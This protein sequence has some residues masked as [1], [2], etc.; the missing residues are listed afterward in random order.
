M[1]DTEIVHP[2]AADEME[3]W[4]MSLATTFLDDPATVAA[5]VPARVPSW[6]ADRAW[7]ARADGRWVATLRTTPR[8]LT[9]PGPDTEI[10][11]DALTNVTVSATHRRQGLLRAML[12]ESL[13]SARDRG[14][15][16]SILIAAEW[17]IY[18]RFG[19]APSSDSAR[20]TLWTR[21]PGS[22]LIG[23]HTGT[24]RQVTPDELGQVAPE[25]FATARRQRAGNID[26]PSYWRDR[27]LGINGIRRGDQQPVVHIV[28]E[29]PDGPDG[30]VTW[31]ST[32]NWSLTGELGEVTVRDLIATNDEAYLSLWQYLIGIDVVDRI[33]LRDRPVDEP[34]HWL[35]EDGRVLRQ[36]H[37]IDWMWLRIIDV[38]AALSA[39]RYAVD[40]S[41]V[42]E[43]VDPD[44]P[45]GTGRPDAPAGT[46][47]AAGRYVLDGSTDGA[48]CRPTTRSAD[49][50][51]H[52]RALAASY[53]GGVSL[54]AQL[55]TGLVE[56]VTT[57]ALARLDALLATPLAPW[58]ATGF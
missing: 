20:Y 55:P 24:T 37:R 58:C 39:R 49:L 16:V 41:V 48:Q 18:G 13:R 26:R 43:V 3:P 56:E 11:A 42:L 46:G 17:P 34:L 57:G 40:G 7:G 22:R 19:Y 36:T 6:I 21:E 51:I 1:S 28:H 52:Q 29:G 10:T 5:D 15:A 45:T 12:D 32:G 38:A 4:L 9:V 30:Y 50:R 33:Q 31:A 44:Q 8:Q 35:L 2:V 54:T 53:L 47:F 14:E 27:E 25:I 23:R